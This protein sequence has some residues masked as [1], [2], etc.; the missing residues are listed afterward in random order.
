[1]NVCANIHINPS[2]LFWYFSLDQCAGPTDQQGCLVGS[3]AKERGKWRFR[4]QNTAALNHKS[5]TAKL[6]LACIWAFGVI[7]SSVKH[8]RRKLTEQY[9]NNQSEWKPSVGFD[10]ERERTVKWEEKTTAWVGSAWRHCS[11]SASVSES[12]FSVTHSGDKCVCV[13]GWERKC[14]CMTSDPEVTQHHTRIHTHTVQTVKVFVLGL[15][16]KTPS[17]LY[18]WS[19]VFHV[20]NSN[21]LTQHEHGYVQ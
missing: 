14:D 8:R 12:V 21:L 6:K 1:M 9:N 18:R 2:W 15:P 11:K 20:S 5:F 10:P 3:M 13:C 7:Q 4:D 19:H 16:L 17:S